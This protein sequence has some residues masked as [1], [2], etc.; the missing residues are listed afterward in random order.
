MFA[1]KTATTSPKSGETAAGKRVPT[2]TMSRDS[3][4]PVR[5]RESGAETHGRSQVPWSIA[6]ISVFPRVGNGGLER[7]ADAIADQALASG[8][9][10]PLLR[11]GL[12]RA[13][14][15]TGRQPAAAA[16]ALDAAAFTVGDDI[17]FAQGQY[18]PDTHIGQRLIAHE[19]VHVAQQMRVGKPMVQRQP[20]GA[21]QMPPERITGS[22][23]PVEQSVPNLDRLRGAGVTPDNPAISHVDADVE[24]NSPD[25]NSVL[26]F[27]ATG[28]DG[29][30]ILQKLGQ[31][32]RMPG[33]DSDSIR[34]VQAVGMAAHVPDGPDAVKGYF[35]SM[36][37]Q[38]MLT[39]QMSG[40]KKTAV[41]VLK[42][43]S[44][45]ID[46]KRATFGDLSWA[47]EALHDLF[48]DDVSGTPLGDVPQQVNPAL[49]LSKNMQ[50]MDVWCDMPQQ[51]MAQ[52][53]QLKPSEQLLIEE[54]TVSLNTAFDQLA[55][56]KVNVQ[57]GRSVTVDINGRPTR[58]RRIPTDQRPPHTALDFNR[59]TRSGHQL[60]IIR[61]SA[62]NELRLYEPEITPSGRHFDGLAADGSNLASYF[63]DQP[64]FGI[65][66]YIEIIGKLTPGLTAPTAP[67]AAHP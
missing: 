67:G 23:N 28:W 32:D 34:C 5:S 31:Y 11:Q 42:G 2:Q 43:V 49:D 30:E 54:W 45:R 26:P 13:R 25:P 47:Q 12:E 46:S 1:S 24:R 60:L 41:D 51:V 64:K 4:A 14:I 55:E 57:E 38:G 65:Y 9:A 27:K 22:L 61:D 48:Y 56:Q 52:A 7:E 35:G 3:H 17:M 62:S 18:R 15:H 8:R 63:R 21:V 20:A 33:T 66:C 40:R 10:H 44:A 50:S 16:S 39:G 58:I 6:E 36:I 59:D 53:E 19:A 37:L 29:N